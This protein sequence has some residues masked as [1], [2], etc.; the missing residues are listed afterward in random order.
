MF[1]RVKA[2]HLKITL[3]YSVLIITAIIVFF[4]IFWTIVTS[5]KTELQAFDPTFIPIIQFQPT[6]KH[7]IVELTEA[8]PEYIK[9]ISN[10]IIVAT[11]STLMVLI[12]GFCAGYALARFKI[13]IGPMQNKDIVTWIFSQII[14]PPA[15]IIIPFFLIIKSFG[16]IDHQ[17]GLIIAHTTIN[18]PL[19][20]L[21]SRDIVMGIPREIEESSMVDGCSNF[22]TIYRITLPL[23][24][25]ALVPVGLICFA[26]SWNE[27][28]FALTLTYQ[29]ATTIPLLVSGAK[30]S[31]G[32]M[33]W[34]VAVRCLVAIIPPVLLSFFVQRYIVKGL[35]LGA[36]K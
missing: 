28:I 31:R 12:I 18:L 30:W 36:V 15:V 7:W 22:S 10:S 35:T 11:V 34:Y 4:P 33:F 13:K 8:R 14:I 26:F 6:L 16:L 17:I 2:K 19:A 20:V 27:F 24:L 1:Y 23:A 21:L 29:K 5:L 3:T 9:S 25:P 32:I